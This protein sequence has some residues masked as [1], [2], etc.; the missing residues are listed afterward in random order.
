M[1]LDSYASLGWTF[2]LICQPPHSPDTN[3]LDISIN[4]ILQCLQWAY[5]GPLNTHE[6]VMTV[7]YNAWEAFDHTRIKK[8]FC[9][10]MTNYDQIIH[11]EGKNCYKTAHI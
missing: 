4:N 6:C 10:L 11:H 1:V 2:N 3:I 9:T 8:A 5:E 7:V